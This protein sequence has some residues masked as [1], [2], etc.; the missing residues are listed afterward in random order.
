MIFT[1]PLSPNE[2]VQGPG[3]WAG[4]SAIPHGPHMEPRCGLLRSGYGL[5]DCR[6]YA[7]GS[8]IVTQNCFATA[9]IRIPFAAWLDYVDTYLAVWVMGYEKGENLCSHLV[10]PRQ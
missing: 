3:A 7:A 1:M 9:S 8:A 4:L 2:P 10:A 6:H 5:Q